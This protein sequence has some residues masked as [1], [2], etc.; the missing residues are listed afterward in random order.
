MGNKYF[1]AYRKCI[2]KKYEIE[3]NGI[4]ANFLL[5]PTEA[6]LRNLCIMLFREQEK[7]DDLQSFKLYFGFEFSI[8]Q[9]FELN[10][11]E[12]MSKFKTI[13]KFFSKGKSFLQ[14][15]NGLDL[16][17][18][19]VGFDERPFNRFSKMSL[20]EIENIYNSLDSQKQEKEKTKEKEKEKKDDNE[21][22]IKI[23]FLRKYI[24]E[25]S[26][27]GSSL[28]LTFLGINYFT[29]EKECMA[30]IKDHYQEIDCNAMNENPNIIVIPK[31]EKLI[32][33]F[34]KIIPCDTTPYKKNGKACLW[35]GKSANKNEYE[36]FTF[37]DVH[38]ET[39]KTLKEVTATIMNNYGKGP[40]Q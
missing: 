37:H 22:T 18:M 5:N 33:N 2:K 26:I 32:E 11:T 35:Y 20:D 15:S 14:D 38:P 24:R 36:F 7:K 9:T 19:L 10:K 16:A 40:C 23:N 4:H 29:S 21:S 13:G 3:K 30:W 8:D 12:P 34:K 17:A 27:A 39:G 6:R 1:D 28:L 31:D 25:I